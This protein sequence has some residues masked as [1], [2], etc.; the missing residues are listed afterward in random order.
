MDERTKEL[1]AVGASAA[2]NCH[3][4]M[5]YHLGLLEKL[6]ASPEDIGAA[7]ETGLQVSKGAWNKTRKVVNEIQG[8]RHETPKADVQTTGCC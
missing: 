5:D 8:G 3:P 6:G 4:C 7:L 2:V 1:V